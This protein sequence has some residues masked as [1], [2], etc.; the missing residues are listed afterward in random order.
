MSRAVAS[1]AV[2]IG[3]LII[4]TVIS[5]LPLLLVLLSVGIASAL[6]CRLDEA[7]VHP[8]RAGGMDLGPALSNGFISLWLLLFVWP[9]MLIT[10]VAWVVLLVR[11][12]QRKHRA[13]AAQSM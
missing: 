12:L 6:G 10:L 7:S 4:A 9:V 13:R 2:G 1:R 11:M 8:C 5:W 3:V